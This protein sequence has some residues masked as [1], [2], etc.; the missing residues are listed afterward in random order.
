MAAA[1]HRL[2]VSVNLSPVQFRCGA[3]PLQVAHILSETG[4]CAELLD[5]ELT[6]TTM[7][8]DTEAVASQLAALRDLG[9]TISIDDFGTGFS[10]LSYV[11][12]FPADR[13]K[14]DQSFVR[15]VLT[16][17]NDAA[18]VRAVLT[19]G[20]SFGM[21]VVAEGV[22]TAAQAA[23]LA[24]EGCVELQGYHFGRPVPAR[25]DHPSG[26]RRP[27]RGRA[28]VTPALLARPLRRLR[29]GFSLLRRR[30][31]ARPDSE[32]EMSINRLVF[33]SLWIIGLAVAAGYGVESE[34]LLRTFWAAAVY[35]AIGIGIF[36]HILACPGV[37][38]R[39]R[40]FAMAADFSVISYG[41]W[42][43]GEAAGWLYPLYLWTVFGNGFRSVCPTCTGRWRS[44]SP[45][46]SSPSPWRVTGATIR[47]WS[48]PSSSG[49]SSCRSTPAC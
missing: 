8:E 24:A 32:H 1:G 13:L 33:A 15:D 41:A 31:K 18:I 27:A 46:S 22:E 43:E 3:L 17:P 36:W 20:R 38:V 48:W 2:R 9:V 7:M 19:L 34:L 6:E 12:R 42:A 10:S 44:P 47:A 35:L 5:L 30:L 11:K 21:A 29:I 37:D 25:G 14:I 4:A 40:V 16:D 28:Q 45:A 26:A 39:R 23:Y 49:S